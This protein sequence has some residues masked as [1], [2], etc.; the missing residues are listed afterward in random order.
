MSITTTALPL[1][2]DHDLAERYDTA[3]DRLLRYHPD[4]IGQM[5]FLA[6]QPDFP[7]GQVLNAYLSL[8]STDLPDVRRARAATANLAGAY[9]NDREQAHFLS[10][11]Y[12][13]RINCFFIIN[14]TMNRI[15]NVRPTALSAILIQPASFAVV[16][17]AV[18]SA[19]GT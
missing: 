18:E 6:Q 9:L 19:L 15:R 10:I 3:I 17:P 16:R 4:V 11:N 2:G 5:I 7:M 1:T 8:S 12:G 13:C 14:L